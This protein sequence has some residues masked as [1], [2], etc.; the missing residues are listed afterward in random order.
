MGD[1]PLAEAYERLKRLRTLGRLSSE[2]FR[3]MRELI[4]RDAALSVEVAGRS[5][6]PVDMIRIVEIKTLADRVFGDERK[7]GAWLGRP[8]SALS[9]QRPLDLLQDELGAAVI[10]EMLE[11]IDHGIFA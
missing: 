6:D 3:V 4:E 9:G 10:R 2:A 1:T 5:F 11:R 7:A 8:N